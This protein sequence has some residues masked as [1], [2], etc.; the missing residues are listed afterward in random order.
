MVKALKRLINISLVL[1]LVVIFSAEARAEAVAPAPAPILIAPNEKTITA[2]LKPLIIGLAKNN[3]KVKI[4]IDGVL[5]GETGILKHESGT[6]NFAQRPA[7]NLTRGW[8]KVYAVAEDESGRSSLQ[9]ETL[10]F[11]IELPFPA[12]TMFKPVVN[13]DTALNR[14]FIVGLA[15]NDSKIKIYI[16]KKYQGELIV[17]NHPSGTANFAYKPKIALTRGAHSVYTLALDRRGKKSIESNAINFITKSAAIAES[18]R[19]EKKGA[20]VKIKEPAKPAK[21]S[22]EAPVISGDSGAVAVG[23]EKGAA[24]PTKESTPEKLDKP[25]QTG[26]E[27]KQRV[28][29][30]E[31]ADKKEAALEKIKNLFG[32]G[33]ATQSDSGLLDES[34]ENQGR[35][36][37]SV[38]LFILFL[39]GV[40]AWLLWV[41]RELVKERRAR[42]EAEEKAKT[43]NKNNPPGADKSDKL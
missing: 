13:R 41:N 42:N 3:A 43:K 40:L 30:K 12:P 1:F 15:K 36:K 28:I 24:E 16:D 20:V 39:I 7:L 11:K 9:S 35:L 8:H 10:N 29:K 22:P 25:A 34:R 32:A 6:A 33:K 26:L 21:L 38:V 4:F 31:L 14:P 37:F 2:D 17:K 18:A 23:P 19:E 27:E 5:N